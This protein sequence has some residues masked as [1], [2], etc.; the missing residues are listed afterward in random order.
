MENNNKER[1]ELKVVNLSP[2]TSTECRAHSKLVAD[3]A[4]AMRHKREDLG[5]TQKAF[6]RK[7]GISLRVVSKLEDCDFKDVSTDMLMGV[8]AKLEMMEV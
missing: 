4:M 6:A 5:I 2:E 3:V 1:N 8:L 7:I